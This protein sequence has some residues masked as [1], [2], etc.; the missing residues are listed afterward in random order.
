M[1]HNNEYFIS[2]ALAEARKA[3]KTGEVPVGAVIVRDDRIIAR[4]RNKNI[5]KND[6]TA[7]AEMEAMRAASKKLS[8]YRLNGCKLYV[9]IEPCA[10]C[11]GAMV[12]ARIS[13][14]VFGAND[15][16]AG[17]CGS[18][19][20]IVYNK[21]LNHRVKITGGVLEKQ[22]RSLIRRF[23]EKRRA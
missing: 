1:K 20:N 14:V 18:V 19:F 23:F 9:T 8:N 10:M 3:A 16:K 2:Q 6:P 11:A 15:P 13:E 17:A 5:A 12:W 21:K 7:H 4:G 22:C